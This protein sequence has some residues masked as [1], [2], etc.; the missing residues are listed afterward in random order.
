M[1]CCCRELN[2]IKREQFPWMYDVTKTAVQ[3]AIIDLGA[4]FRAFFETRG[5]Y[6]GSSNLLI[7][8]KPP[9]QAASISSPSLA[10]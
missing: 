2:A 9:F 8:P 5:R 4:A 6:L 10:G 7:S 3:E 1:M